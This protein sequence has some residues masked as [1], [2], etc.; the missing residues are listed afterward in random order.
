[1]TMHT[2]RLSLFTALVGLSLTLAPAEPAKAQWVVFD[3]GNFSQNILTAIRTLMSNVNE[4]E[5]I[6]NQIQQINNEIQNLQHMP[7]ALSGALLGDYVTEWNRMQNTFAA[8][9]GLS[10]N[11]GTLAVNYQNLFPARGAGALTGPQVIAQL[12]QYLAQA[13]QTYEGVYRQSGAVMAALPQAQRDMAT[14]LA[15]SNGATGNLDAIQAQ[16]QMTAQ[17][18]QLLVQQNAQIAAMN[19]AQADWLNQQMEMFDTVRVMQTQSEAR[20]PQTQPPA[21][22]LPVIH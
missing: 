13:R 22:Y 7:G 15:A 5:Q 17:V 21:A 8:I 1:M 14:T 18:A 16:T 3:P 6:A 10:A 9:N 4:V 12:Q 20:I 11:I 2:V 19:Q